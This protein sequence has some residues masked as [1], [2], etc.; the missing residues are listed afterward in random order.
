MKARRG[1]RL[2]GGDELFNGDIW[3]GQAGVDAG[4]ADD[5]GHLA[6]TM[7]ALYGDKVR[8]TVIAPRRPLFRR[9]GLPGVGEA[10]DAV[11]ARALW[12]RYGL[13]AR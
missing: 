3:V 2:N 13:P 10:L 8:F 9:L 4:L 12:S 5:I 11:E 7:K 1:A 6:P